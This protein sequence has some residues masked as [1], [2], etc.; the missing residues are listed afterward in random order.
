LPDPE[1]LLFVN[2]YDE[3]INIGREY[4]LLPAWVSN[5]IGDCTQIKS[6]DKWLEAKVY[7]DAVANN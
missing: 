1:R 3:Y 6:R 2:A 4:S 5:A 7:D